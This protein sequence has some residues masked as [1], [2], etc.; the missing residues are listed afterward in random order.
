MKEKLDKNTTIK[1]IVEKY[2]KQENISIYKFSKESKLSVKTIEKI[3]K[4]TN[5]NFNKKT[6]EK[7]YTLKKLN[8]D[9]KKDIRLFL[10]DKKSKKEND[11]EKI[12]IILSSLF[13]ENKKLKEENKKLETL[14]LILADKP[15]KYNDLLKMNSFKSDF[16]TTTKIIPLMWKLNDEVAKLFSELELLLEINNQEENRKMKI[17][18]N[19]IADNLMNIG[20]KLKKYGENNKNEEQIIDMEVK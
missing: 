2:L 11:I 7:L 8:S 16:E 13:E 9:D 14:N 1:K 6:I 3:L 17:G 15:K 19:K 5:S 4:N 20:T 12:S 10:K 18:L